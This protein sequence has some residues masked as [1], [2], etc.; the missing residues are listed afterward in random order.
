[1]KTVNNDK[2]ETEI[3]VFAPKK[4]R[5]RRLKDSFFAQFLLCFICLFFLALIVYKDEITG[6]FTVSKNENQQKWELS[7]PFSAKRQNILLMGADMSENPDKPFENTRSDSIYLLSVAPHAKD[8]NVISIPRDSKVYIHSRSTPDKINHAFAY[9][10][11]N[12][13][14]KTIEQLLG[15]RIDHYLVVSNQALVDFIDKIG[16]IDV[17]VEKNMHYDDYSAG[18]HINLEKGKRHLTGKQAEGYMRYR[19]DGLG[20]IGRIRRQ[21]WF[22]SALSD[23]LKDPAVIIKMPEII[24]SVSK[25]IQTDFSLFELAQ[26]AALLKSTDTTKIK[27]ATL[28]GEPSQRGIV[29]YWVLDPKG[30]QEVVN[31]FI[32][33]DKPK[34]LERPVEAGILYVESEEEN[35]L[36]LQKALENKGIEVNIKQVKNP[37]HD[38]IAIHNFDVPKE[39]FNELEYDIPI[40]KNKQMVYDIIG[41]NKAARD[42][43]VTLAG[44]Q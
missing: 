36:L 1:M 39:F 14:V 16:G 28:P 31:N 15:I 27:I 25:Y 30:V 24:K 19:K 8:I 13:S 5:V 10:G 32:F 44:S 9:G 12:L 38:H 35:A 4:R 37:G 29:S 21:Q 22:F 41:I 34:A 6:F 33:N 26:Y 3:P 7:L 43:T 11:I 23:K 42:F 20:D 40:L 2:N 17:Y 18:L